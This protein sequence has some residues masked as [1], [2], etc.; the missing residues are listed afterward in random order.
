MTYF[1]RDIEIDRLFDNFLVSAVFSILGIRFFLKVTSYPQLGGANFHI[2]HMLWGGFFMLI[3]ITLLLAF[4]N[5]SI[6]NISSILGGIGF[7]VFID[8]LGKFITR[9]NNYFYKPTIAFIYVIF[10]LLYLLFRAI[11]KHKSFTKEEYSV[12]RALGSLNTQPN[13]AGRFI[14]FLRNFYH[15]IIK[16]KWFVRGL[17]IFFVLKTIVTLLYI[18]FI[19]AVFLNIPYEMEI[20]SLES[21]SSLFSALFVLIGIYKLRISRITGYRFFK[22][23]VLVAIFLTQVFSFYENQFAALVGLT[24]NIVV[25]T[26]LDYMIQEETLIEG[27]IK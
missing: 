20:E 16:K 14:V 27:Q 18:S 25:L 19:L 3:A 13:V 23:S 21:G 7:G 9:D 22:R 24:F 26:A 4:I 12:N 1:I 17:I 6:K 2:A 5:R 15:S 10:I 11:E 8:E